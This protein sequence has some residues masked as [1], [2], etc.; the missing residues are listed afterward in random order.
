ML[1]DLSSSSNIEWSMIK[2]PLVESAKNIRAEQFPE[3]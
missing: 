1:K 3:Q 2:K